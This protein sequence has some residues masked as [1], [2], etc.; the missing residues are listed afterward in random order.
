MWA[1]FAAVGCSS[2]A[3]QNYAAFQPPNLPLGDEA[4]TRHPPGCRHLMPMARFPAPVS[5]RISAILCNMAFVM[6]IIFTSG[7]LL[8]A[9]QFV[10]GAVQLSVESTAT[11]PSLT[12]C[13]CAPTPCAMHT[14]C[15][16]N[17]HAC[18]QALLP[19]QLL[20]AIPMLWERWRSVFASGALPPFASH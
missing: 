5:C 11:I 8:P 19:V 7:H 4:P 10:D 14:S 6:R 18:V 12:L 3:S 1:S 2:T 16:C 17:G 15:A 9:S 13:R 20:P